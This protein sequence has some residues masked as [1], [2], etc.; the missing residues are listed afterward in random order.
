MV[1]RVTTG[2]LRDESVRGGGMEYADRRKK[3]YKNL[4]VK[5]EDDNIKR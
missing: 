3:V 4:A 2:V 1:H 5:L